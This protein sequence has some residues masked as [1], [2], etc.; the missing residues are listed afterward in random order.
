MMQIIVFIYHHLLR[1]GHFLASTRI[2][3][4][5]PEVMGCSP[6]LAHS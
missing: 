5:V 3:G 1:R 4:R 2:L 6:T